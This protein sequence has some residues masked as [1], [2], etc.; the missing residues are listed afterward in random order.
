MYWCHSTLNNSGDERRGWGWWR[1]CCLARW[2]TKNQNIR[3]YFS[4]FIFL[5][6]PSNF[7]SCLYFFLCI[8]SFSSFLLFFLD[9]CISFF[10]VYFFLPL[11]TPFLLISHF[12][13]Y[14]SFT[15][16]LPLPPFRLS[17]SFF[18]L[19]FLLITILA[20]LS[21]TFVYSSLPLSLLFI[22]FTYFWGYVVFNTF[23]RFGSY[24]G[25]FS[26]FFFECLFLLPF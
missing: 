17:F 9:F 14:F 19:H 22:F 23:L 13:C 8:P 15:L 11:L 26:L 16:F 10:P 3:I 24:C 1:C 6:S 5:L 21:P 2:N 7:I 12:S 4:T 25:S 18:F 20:N